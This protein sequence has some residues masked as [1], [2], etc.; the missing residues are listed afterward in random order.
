MTWNPEAIQHAAGLG[1]P[2][3]AH[4]ANLD[5]IDQYLTELVQMAGFQSAVL[6]NPE[7]KVIVASDRKK[8][9]ENFSAI[10]PGRIS[11]SQG[12]QGGTFNQWRVACHHSDHGPESAAG[13][14]GRGIH[15]ACLPAEVIA[16]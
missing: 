1:H 14:T 8:R 16:L 13:H 7:D 9:A 11:A 12:G 4:G 5:Q 10:Y 15:F 6:A 2:S 3:G